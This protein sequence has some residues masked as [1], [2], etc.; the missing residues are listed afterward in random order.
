MQVI[1]EN[2]TPVEFANDWN[3]LKKKMHSLMYIQGDH[4]KN[5]TRSLITYRCNFNPEC[6]SQYSIKKYPE[7]FYV[8]FNNIQHSQICM[9]EIA[10]RNRII[11]MIKSGLKP[12][13]I[14]ETLNQKDDLKLIKQISNQKYNFKKEESQSNYKK[15]GIPWPSSGWHLPSR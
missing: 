13:K 6:K 10:Q 5:T 15:S 12:A 3:D 9:D 4:D 11:D 7:M 2:W 1:R 14:A 8:T